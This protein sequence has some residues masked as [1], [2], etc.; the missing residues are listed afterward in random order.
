MKKA[1]K[2]YLV[3]GAVRDELLARAV[4]ERDW[5]V[6]GATPAE[7]V[8][9]GYHQVG[10]DF[11]VF[12]HPRTKEEYALARKERKV[13]QGYHGFVF[14][15]DASVSLE[16]D[17]MRRDLTIN[18]IAKDELGNVTDPYQGQD[19]LKA[20]ILRHVSPAFAEDPVRILRVARFA[21]RFSDFSVAEETND[22]MKQMVQA[23][24]VNALVAERVWKEFEKAMTEI[25]P[26]RF[27]EVL[28][29]CGALL[30]LFPLFDRKKKEILDCLK[31]SSTATINTFE[32][33]ALMLQAT[34]SPIE[35]VALCQHYRAPK[36]LVEMTLLVI[37]HQLQYQE[38]MHCTA[39]EML[40]L[41]ILLD[42]FR[43]EERFK[44]WLRICEI[45]TSQH[46]SDYFITAFEK[47][48]KVEISREVSNSYQGKAIGDYIDKTRLENL[49]LF[50]KA[51]QEKS[52]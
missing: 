30:I 20:K 10:K 52:R 44:Q 15:T 4:H 41:L 39:E 12:L 38:I 3:G 42:A 11:P 5:V 47:I 51:Y 2:I 31:K 23:G 13:A 33:M 6:V 45:S 14:D 1:M 43:R 22:L 21:A 27:M 32:R 50:I 25:A 9:L 8:A 49:T 7:M 26:W 16:E 48:K 46:H 18:A 34:N 28:E 36:P 19:D 29:D 35:T 40:N 24:E 17:L 37:Q